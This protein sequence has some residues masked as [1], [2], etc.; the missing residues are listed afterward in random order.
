MVTHIT[1]TKFTI[2]IQFEI[3]DQQFFLS[4]SYT[5][6]DICLWFIILITY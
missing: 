1:Y 4:F 3:V 2:S 5:N 6:Y